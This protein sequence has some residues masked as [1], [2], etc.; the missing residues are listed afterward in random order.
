MYAAA[1]KTRKP[2]RFKCLESVLCY[3]RDDG[4]GCSGLMKTG[5]HMADL[6]QQLNDYRLTTAEI[7]YHMPDHPKLLQTFIWQDYDIAPQFPV[8]GKFLS[9][10]TREL[11]GKLHSVYVA[12]QKLITPNDTRFY[13]TEIT[14]Q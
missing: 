1:A 10:W 4:T 2:A 13:D 3:D 8:L 9:F 14:L 11:D 6:I 5:V 12:N 7:L